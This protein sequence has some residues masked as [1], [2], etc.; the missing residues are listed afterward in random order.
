MAVSIRLDAVLPYDHD[1]RRIPETA[2][3]AESL[4]FQALWAAETRH[5]PFLP[6]PLIAEHTRRLHFGTAIAVSFARS[7]TTLAYTAWDLARQSGGRFT[8][9]L[10]TQVRGHVERRFGMPWPDSPVGK[11]REQIGALRAIWKSWQEGKALKFHGEFY[12]LTL[13]PP[14]FD[15]GPIEHPAIPIFIAGVNTGLAR[16]AG[17]AAQGFHVHPLHTPRYL[18]EV[19]RPA[20]ASGAR[21]ARRRPEDVQVSVTAFVIPDDSSR[22]E[23]RQ[24][25]AFYAATPSYRSVLA[26]HGWESAGEALG[27]MAARQRWEEMPS[28]IDDTILA[29]FAVDLSRSA[30]PAE[31]LRLRYS[32]LADRLSLY[33][34]LIPGERTAFWRQ[35]LDAWE[36][37]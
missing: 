28:V 35:L 26:L 25:I 33:L 34:P 17:E 37:G 5:N 23:V 20:I 36:A 2:R 15:P 11:L 7:P 29:A 6:G 32:G 10:G 27:R 30:E 24:Q 8:L 12:R 13:M 14:F 22:E 1:L 21:K 31:A 16:L 4:G 19:I 9:G 18:A 3:L